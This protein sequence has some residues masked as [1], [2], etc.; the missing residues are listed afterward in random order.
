[1]YAYISKDYVTVVSGKVS[2][3]GDTQTPSS[4][5]GITY[6]VHAQ[7]YGWMGE[8]KD[9]AMAGTEGEA[10]R[11]EAVKIKLRDPSVSGSVKYRSHIQSIGWTDWKS[12][13]AM[14]GTEGQAKRMEA[15][16]IQLTGKMAEKYDIYYRVHCQT[17]GW[18]D[19]AKNGETAGTTDGAKR[20]EHWR[21][22]L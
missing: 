3:G 4:S 22:G 2:G 21:S 6:S 5:E 8:Q 17:Y 18:L 1:M 15:I 14:S 11:L 10:K 16:Q 7:T 19:W 9:G 20:M 12:D 13:G